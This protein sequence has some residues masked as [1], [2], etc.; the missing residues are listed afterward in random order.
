M[1]AHTVVAV[2]FARWQ[3]AVVEYVALVSA[4]A[5]AAVVFGARYDQAVVN[6]RVEAVGQRL[7]EAGPAGAG[8]RTWRQ[9]R[10]GAA[11]SRRKGRCRPAARG[12]G[13]WRRAARFLP[14][15]ARQKQQQR[16]V[17]ASPPR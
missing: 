9:K 8:C 14:A 17:A 15:A 1:R 3:R 10:R 12:A 2:A 13:C 6:L 5:A 16:G 7:P 11:R 4:A